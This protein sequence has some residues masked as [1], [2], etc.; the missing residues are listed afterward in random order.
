M[1]N[2]SG[3]I[4]ILRRRGCVLKD[5]SDGIGYLDGPCS[6]RY[7]GVNFLFIFFIIPY[8]GVRVRVVSTHGFICAR[9]GGI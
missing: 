6:E 1:T 4:K 7:F 5:E 8:F 9:N 2:S 3:G